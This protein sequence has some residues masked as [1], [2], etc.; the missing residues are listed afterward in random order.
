[1]GEAAPRQNIPVT[2]LVLLGL[3]GFPHRAISPEITPRTWPLVRSGGRAPQGGI[4][5]LPSSTDPGFCSLLTGCHPATHGVR[6]T[7]WRFA[8]LPEWA[9]AE[10]PVVATIFD[11]CRQR[12][13]RTASVVSDDRGLLATSSADQRWPPDG[14]LPAGIA[15]DA[16]GYPANREV[17]RRLLEAVRDPTVG[18]V[19]GHFNEADTVGHDH[20][21]Q[22]EAAR[23]CYA[24]TDRA[25]GDVLD[26]LADGWD[27]TIVVIVS[28]HD[29]QPRDGSTPI[30]LMAHAGGWWDLVIPDGGG[31]LVHLRPGV[32]RSMAGQ[33]L[34]AIEG[35]E[36]WM[37]GNQSMVIAG[38]KP[39][40][41]FSAPRYPAAG[42]HGAPVTA[43][44]VAIVGGGHPAVSQL[45]SAIARRQPHLADWA[46]TVAPILGI[47]L[48]WADGVN[49]L[50]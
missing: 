38:A 26:A 22:S 32:D 14:G 33:A 48:P 21:P 37:P 2:R 36:T 5:D 15:L 46:P 29:M 6:T 40:R 42:F 43:R 10:T 16:H 30:D 45:S 17:L 28:D 18:F 44:T 31:A 7:S 35:V 3:D 34:T 1:M 23:D 25:V 19:F 11:A 27:D 50:A 49:L 20:G 13:I 8:R 4:T 47:D 9:G 39:G 41:I 24:A 12:G